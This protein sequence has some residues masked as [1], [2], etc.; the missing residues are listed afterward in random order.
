V[1]VRIHY[2]E[3]FDGSSGTD[4][5]ISVIRQR[6]SLISNKDLIGL[7]GWSGMREETNCRK[8]DSGWVKIPLDNSTTDD[9]TQAA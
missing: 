1:S 9:Q 3:V 4:K 7:L 2:P 8:A 5:R 6:T